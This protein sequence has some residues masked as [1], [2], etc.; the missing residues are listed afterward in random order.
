[1]VYTRTEWRNSRP[2]TTLPRQ[3]RPK[4]RLACVLASPH[5]EVLWLRGTALDDVYGDA[6]I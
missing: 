1:M 3:I 5:T 6:G 2:A 4:M